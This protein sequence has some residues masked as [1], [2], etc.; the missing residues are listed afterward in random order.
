M[1]MFGFGFPRQGFFSL[2][3]PR[4]A[5]PS[6]APEHVG[7]ISLQSG[8]AFVERM[9]KELKHLIDEKWQWKVKQISHKEYLASFPNKQILEA[10]SRSNGFN[11]ALYNISASLTPSNIDMAASFVLQTGWVQIFKVLDFC[12]TMEVVTENAEKAGEVIAVDELSL[13]KDEPIRVKI[14]GRD[15]NKIWSLLEFFVE[16]VGF[17]VKF[18]P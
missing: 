5:R 3:I 16:S 1:H 17:E 14:K 11:L 4:L 9:E 15:I 10:F 8:E 6:K 18:V 2:K 7:L 12:R 13:I